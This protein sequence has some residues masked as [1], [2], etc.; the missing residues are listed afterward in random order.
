MTNNQ[1]YV[2]WF[3]NSAPYI[4]AHRGRTFVIQFGGEVVLD[5]KFP[6]LIHDIA[7]LNSLGVSLVLVHGARPQIE[8]RLVERGLSMRYVNGL[9]IT[10]EKA[11]ALVKEGVGCVRLEIEALLSMGL[12]NSPM[13]GACIRVTSGNFVTARPIGVRKGVDFCYTGEVRRVDGVSIA[14]LLSDEALV[15]VSPLGFSLTGEIF[16]LSAEDVATAIAVELRAAKLLLLGEFPGLTDAAGTLIRQLTLSD[17]KS[18]VSSRRYASEDGEGQPLRH[19]VSA[20]HACTNGVRR[21]HL[22]DSGVDGALLL[23]LFTRDGIGT[24]VSAD[25]YE[26]TRRATID[27]VGGILEL[28]EP[29]EAEGILVRRSREKFETEIERFFVMERDGAVIACAA[30]YPFAD[31]GV[32]E[33]ACLAVHRDYRRGNRADAMLAAVETEARSLGTAHLFVLTTRASHWFREH[34]FTAASIEDLPIARQAMYNYKRNSKVLIK[35][36]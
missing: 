14:K 28:I 15:L 23:E 12:T 3:R 31:E 20:I 7:L 25:L 11:L 2:E 10:D 27:D 18:L 9:R 24:M 26:N 19:L 4:H 21:T 16:N 32:A 35:A 22:M 13:A 30:V 6:S 1:R 8:H 5:P 36:L 17:A 29:L 33:L 34:G